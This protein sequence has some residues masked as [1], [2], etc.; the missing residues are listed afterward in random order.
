MNNIKAIYF[1]NNSC[2]VCT[3]FLPKME[4]IAKDYGISLESIDITEKPELAGQNMVF[5]I[6][7]IIFFDLEGKEVKR[8]ARSFS[9]YEIRDFLD[10][11]KELTM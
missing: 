10:R 3:A 11:V 6:P 7:T 9:E 4:K 1:K 5:T 8:F 2:G